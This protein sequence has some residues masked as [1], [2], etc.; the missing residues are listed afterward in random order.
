MTKQGEGAT[1]SLHV[2]NCN[3][4]LFYSVPPPNISLE[5]M[6][7]TFILEV[8]SADK[9]VQCQEHEGICKTLLS[10]TYRVGARGAPWRVCPSAH[11]TKGEE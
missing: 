5:A 11:L 8:S 3:V 10:L 6:E 2:S 9:L 7:Q 1:P 4:K